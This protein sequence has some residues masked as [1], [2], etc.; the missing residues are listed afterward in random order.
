MQ[1]DHGKKKSE[2][3]DSTVAPVGLVPKI[4][5]VP[6]TVFLLCGPTHSGKSTFSEDLGYMAEYMALTFK[7]LSSDEIRKELLSESRVSPYAAHTTDSRYSEGMSAVSRQ[8]FEVLMLGLKTHLSFP[9]CTDVVV[10]DTT[11]MNQHF[12]DSV[13]AISIEAGYKVCL[14]TFEYKY[15]SDY[16]PEAGLSVVARSI[17]ERSVAK[18]RQSILP[19]LPIREY[20]SRIR[21]KS[22][23]AFGWD[24]PRE[25]EWWDD[26]S[27][28]LWVENA[29]SDKAKAKCELLESCTQLNYRRKAVSGWKAAAEDSAELGA[30]QDDAPVFAVIGDSHECVDEL[31]TLVDLIEAKDPKIQIVHCG[32]YLD[33]GQDTARMVNFMHSRLA[34]GDVIVT[35]NHEQFV[36]LRLIQKPETPLSENEATYFTSLKVLEADPVLAAKFLEIY[37]ASKPFAV[38]CDFDNDGTLP[39]YVTHAPCENKYLAKVH[40]DALRAQRNY[41]TV[42]REKQVRDEFQ[43]LYNEADY[44]LPLHIFGHVSHR[45][46]NH[47]GFQYKNKVFLDSGVVHGGPLTAVVVK[48]GKVQYYLQAPATR[49]R[50]EAELPVDLGSGPTVVTKPFNIYDYDLDKKDLRLLNQVMDKGVK[51]ISGTMAPAPSLN[52]KLEPLDGALDWFS[53]LG[54]DEVILE[55]KYMGSRCQMYLHSGEPDKTFAT[56]R[57]G[58]IIRGVSGK[59]DEEYKAFLASVWKQHEILIPAGGQL[60]LDGELLPWHALGAGLIE[61][62]FKPY[63]ELISAQLSTLVADEGFNQLTEFTSK[64]NVTDKLAHLS[65]FRSALGLYS[66]AGEPSFKAFDF[67]YPKVTSSGPVLADDTWRCVNSDGYLIVNL[68]D[69]ASVEAGHAFFKKLTVDRGMEGV[70]VKPRI[71]G[72]VNLPYMK[73]R[74]EEYLR[75]VYGYD[76]LDSNRYERLVRQ[77][78]I[79][80]KVRLSISEH[81]AAVAMLTA[82]GDA[83]KELVVKMIGQMKEEKVLDPRL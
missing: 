3:I 59:T 79:S 47:K 77:K 42:D 41:R 22:K 43:W 63:E 6:H 4:D 61:K 29:F 11:G 82:D 50:M 7:I 31:S 58:W 76:Y 15:R 18:F 66:Q 83:K 34:K 49:V 2:V 5:M 19:S 28:D 69:Q 60:I 65:K 52:G 20:D 78:N 46:T 30:A 36:A 26:S 71:E 37:H 13:K 62:N 51:Y 80:R 12:R 75:L 48:Q 40:D 35:G 74:S 38:L 73:V 55:P 32:D 16:V 14:V 17:V 64:F 53:K 67:L 68:K 70:V 23:N 81:A 25:A 21:I 33:K 45:V 27:I 24:L 72:S 57:A 8:A 1:V 44:G 54:C 56:S 39:V 9:I 10:V